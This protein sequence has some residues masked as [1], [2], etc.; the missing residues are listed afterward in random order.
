MIKDVTLFVM[1]ALAGALMVAAETKAVTLE[2]AE[3]DGSSFISRDCGDDWVVY[4]W[5]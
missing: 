2:E 3:R 5:D 4:D 1:A